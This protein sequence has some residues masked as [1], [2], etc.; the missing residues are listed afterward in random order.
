MILS[1]YKKKLERFMSLGCTHPVLSK[2]SKILGFQ[3]FKMLTLGMEPFWVDEKK[4]S[5]Y[6]KEPKNN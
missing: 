2:F 3:A 6:K 5:L 1:Q 4:F